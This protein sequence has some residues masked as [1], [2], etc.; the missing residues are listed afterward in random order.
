[1][2]WTRSLLAF[3]L[4]AVGSGSADA[5]SVT[6]AGRDNLPITD[7]V[8][9]HQLVPVE[10]KRRLNLFCSGEGAPTVILEAG[11]GGDSKVWRNVQARIAAYT[12]VCS[13]DRA[14]YGYSDPAPRPSTASNIA[15]DLHRLIRKA[16]IKTPVVLVGHSS[17]GLYAMLYADRWLPEVAG[18]VLIDP[19]ATHYLERRFAAQTATDRAADLAGVGEMISGREDCLKRA[20]AGQDM[21]P[22]HGLT[23][24]VGAEVYAAL[25]DR[26][27]RPS[28]YETVLSEMHSV[29]DTVKGDL[30]IDDLQEEGEARHFGAMPLT[31]LTRGEMDLPAFISAES[32]TKVYTAWKE[33][34]E[35][36]AA[37]STRGKTVLVP[38]SGHVI[39]GSNP[40]MVAEA[41]RDMVATTRASR[42][43]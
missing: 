27:G 25:S 21:Q 40:E 3:A 15:D 31:V 35:R 18:M 30:T 28:F 26:L 29:F 2:F 14:G 42:R 17:G 37:R 20:K 16:G 24:A 5:Q 6:A 10:G 32:Q 33:D 4:V 9:P 11:A 39:H 1:M 23:P 13:Y 12:R 36:I 41:V 19:M 22:C 38:G 8:A 34:H 7:Y 43:R